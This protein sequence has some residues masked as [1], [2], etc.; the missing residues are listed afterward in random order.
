[1][2]TMTPFSYGGFWDVPR[3]I[4]L[5]YRR[6]FWLL[7][8]EFDDELDEYAASYS[9]YALPDSV[10]ASVRDGNWDFYD[11]TPM[12]HIGAIPVDSILFD[13]T[14]RKELDAS[15][16]DA[17]IDSYDAGDGGGVDPGEPSE[18]AD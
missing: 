2:P 4:V 5:Q 6:R 8:S 7:R 3:Y 15:S 9:V 14:K 12:L 10:A 11:K 13:E 1:M 18:F 16:L 17:L